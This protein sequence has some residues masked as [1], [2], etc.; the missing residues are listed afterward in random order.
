MPSAIKTRWPHHLLQCRAVTLQ[1]KHKGSIVCCSIRDR[2]VRTSGLQTD[3]RKSKG[4][5]QKVIL[6]LL[7]FVSIEQRCANSKSK[8]KAMQH[9]RKSMHKRGSMTDH[10]QSRQ[11]NVF[12]YPEIQPL[13]N[14]NSLYRMIHNN[15]TKN[16]Y[17]QFEMNCQAV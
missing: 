12:L 16:S 2:G 14:N 9:F 5:G 11:S 4:R 1:K 10:P 7:A 15:K 13:K 3:Y 17:F 8:P 6:L